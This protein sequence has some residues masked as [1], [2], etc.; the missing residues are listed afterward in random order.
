MK[1]TSWV[2]SG[3]LALLASFS[4]ALV[5]CGAS[6]DP[7]GTGESTSALGG[8]P[9]ATDPSAAAAGAAANAAGASTG[10][11]ATGGPSAAVCKG[12]LPPICEKCADGKDECA[13]W[14]V[15]HGRCEIEICSPA[16]TPIPKCDGPLPTICEICPDGAEACAHWV[17]ENGVCEVQIC[18]P[19]P[20]AAGSAPAASA[21]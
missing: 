18:P 20:S 1:R 9:S 3:A 7:G 2:G 5:G 15:E 14:V 8:R 6:A 21:N 16:P 12:P 11:T 19:T 10:P 17:V 4:F 13:H